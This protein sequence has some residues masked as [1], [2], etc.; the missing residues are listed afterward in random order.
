MEA[1]APNGRVTGAVWNPATRGTNDGDWKRRS[2]GLL[3]PVD[4]S[5]RALSGRLKFTVRRHNFNEDDFSVAAHAPNG[6][7]ADDQIA[8]I[9]LFSSLILTGTLWNPATCGTHQGDLNRRYGGLTAHA[10][11]M[12]MADD[13]IALSSPLICTGTLWNPAT[14]G[15]DK[16]D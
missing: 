10:P 8:Q 5:F 4:P 11:S 15:T 7:L 6:M 9:A 3:S 2:D 12:M 16:G 1:H 14:C 13:R